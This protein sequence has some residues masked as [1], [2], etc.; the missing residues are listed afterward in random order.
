MH[1]AQR[2]GCSAR[3]SI[4]T[5][6]A[7]KPGI[8]DEYPTEFEALSDSIRK[9]DIYV[10]F[11]TYSNSGGRDQHATLKIR[12]QAYDNREQLSSSF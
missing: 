4:R 9:Y 3:L 12:K 6:C 10:A 1:H 5:P 7:K 11:S 2:W 8:E